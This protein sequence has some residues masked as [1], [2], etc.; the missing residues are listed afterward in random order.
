MRFNLIGI[1]PRFLHDILALN[2]IETLLLQVAE[3]HI[4]DQ[5]SKKTENFIKRK[6]NCCDS[7]RVESLF[8]TLKKRYSLYKI[9]TYKMRMEDV[10]FFTTRLEFALP[11]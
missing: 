7:T 9:P 11:I 2:N 8:E 1:I 3:I 10:Y 5:Y 4:K 6:N